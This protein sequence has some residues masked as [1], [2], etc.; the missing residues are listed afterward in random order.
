MMAI[1]KMTMT[2]MTSQPVLFTQALRSSVHIG[3]QK[4]TE[5]SS[6][7]Y[8]KFHPIKYKAQKST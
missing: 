2:L 7:K 8:R 5:F 3:S 6:D 1:T 4:L